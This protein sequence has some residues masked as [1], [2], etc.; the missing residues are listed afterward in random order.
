MPPSLSATRRRQKYPFNPERSKQL[1]RQAG[2]TLPV[3]IEFWYPTGVSR[4]YM[5]DP[6]RNF[7]AF[8][9]SLEQSGFKVIAKSAPWRPDYL[10]KVR[11]GHGRAPE[12]DRLDG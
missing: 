2:L 1:L 7:E 3:E 6:K 4:P 5:P 8:A 12:P 9:A 11:R 10:G